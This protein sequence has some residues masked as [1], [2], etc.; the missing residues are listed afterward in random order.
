MNINQLLLRELDSLQWDDKLWNVRQKKVQNKKARKNLCFQH[1]LAPSTQPGSFVYAEVPEEG[2]EPVVKWDDEEKHVLQKATYEEG[3]GTIY[4]FTSFPGLD[5]LSKRV[6]DHLRLCGFN[7]P[8]ENLVIEG[9]YYYDSEDTYIGFHG[10]GERNM[11]F[12]VRVSDYA[13]DH[14]MAQPIYFGWWLN[15]KYVKRSMKSFIL[16]G[17]DAYMM[18]LKATGNDWKGGRSNAPHLRHAAGDLYTLLSNTAWKPYENDESILKELVYIDPE[19]GNEESDIQFPLG[20]QQFV[21]KKVRDLF[22]SGI[23][24]NKKDQNWIAKYNGTYRPPVRKN[25]KAQNDDDEEENDE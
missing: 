25:K 21:L 1:K 11:V 9:N 4:D 12:G 24:H 15:G 22:L 8:L 17:G 3:K 7:M 10:D 23:Y 14:S 6:V 13:P 16:D 5:A 19:T 2:G 20:G 18:S